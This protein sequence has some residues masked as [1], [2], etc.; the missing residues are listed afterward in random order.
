MLR[1]LNDEV[2]FGYGR[3]EEY[4]RK[5]RAAFTDEMRADFL[6]LQESWLHLARSYEFA[7][8]LL[9]FSKENK[10]RRTEFYSDDALS[11]SSI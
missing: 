8:R 11:K 5:A 10:R 1:N 6:R 4:A 3:A 2:T 9:D 7:E